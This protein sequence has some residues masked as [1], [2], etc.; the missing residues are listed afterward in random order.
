MEAEIICKIKWGELIRLLDFVKKKY[1]GRLLPFSATD[2][3]NEDGKKIGH[4]IIAAVPCQYGGI[5][6]GEIEKFLGRIRK[7][8][9]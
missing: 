7:K 1:K 9:N 5:A 6:E 2:W 8:K 4:C 3:F